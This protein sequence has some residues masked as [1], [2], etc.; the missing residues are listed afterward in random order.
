[1]I[2]QDV[3]FGDRPA[4]PA[5]KTG[6]YKRMLDDHGMVVHREWLRAMAEG[7]PVGLCHLCTDLLI[8]Q[9]PEQV[10]RRTDYEAVCRHCGWICNAPN[11]RY[12][13]GTSRRSDR[14]G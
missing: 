13:A 8:P 5:P 7:R 3:L 11:G 12:L 10:G 9:R 6:L 2:D 14:K 1:M 4:S